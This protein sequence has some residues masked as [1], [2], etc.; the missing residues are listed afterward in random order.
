[1]RVPDDSKPASERPGV[2]D[3]GVLSVFRG[4]RAGTDAERL[5]GV[6]RSVARLKL[7]LTVPGSVQQRLSSIRRTA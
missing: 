6:Q 4:P 2:K 7:G 3:T 5:S 1:M